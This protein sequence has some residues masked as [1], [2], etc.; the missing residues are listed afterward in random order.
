MARGPAEVQFLGPG[1]EG[2]FPNTVAKARSPGHSLALLLTSK[3]CWEGGPSETE[4]EDR[5]GLGRSPEC[6]RPGGPAWTEM[7][8]LE[9]T[10]IGVHMSW[11]HHRRGAGGSQLDQSEHML[12]H[13]PAGGCWLSRATVRDE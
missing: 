3:G 7:S 8:G 6:V 9:A 11:S 13:I 12:P 1:P 4:D 5:P 2:C 10:C